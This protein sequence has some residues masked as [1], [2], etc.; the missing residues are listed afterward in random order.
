LTIKCIA[1]FTPGDRIAAPATTSPQTICLRMAAEKYLGDVKA[2]YQCRSAASSDAMA[3]MLSGGISAHFTNAPFAQFEADDKRVHR[4]LS[5]KISW[6]VVDLRSA[7][8]EHTLRRPGS[9]I[10][11]AMVKALIRWRIKADPARA[12]RCISGRSARP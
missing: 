8:G 11:E 1:D 3:A 12:A 10:A 4:V 6:Q 9:E 5:S 7:R 2:R